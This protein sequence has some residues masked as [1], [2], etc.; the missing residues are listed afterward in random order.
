MKTYYLAIIAA[1]L[2]ASTTAHAGG[3]S[4]LLTVVAEGNTDRN[5]GEIV[6]TQRV[7]GANG[8]VSAMA[9]LTNISPNSIKT[10]VTLRNNRQE[11][12]GTIRADQ[13]VSG[14]NGVATTCAGLLNVGC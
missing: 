2:A 14:I 4:A 13:Q 10:T 12:T 5:S 3:L 8:M 7:S 9:G 11:N 1:T 6:A